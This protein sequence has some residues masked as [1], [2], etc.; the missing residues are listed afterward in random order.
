[1]VVSLI[2][3]TGRTVRQDSRTTTTCGHP[4]YSIID[5]ENWLKCTDKLCFS[6]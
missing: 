2:V 4:Q 1:M 5:F 3:R 6:V